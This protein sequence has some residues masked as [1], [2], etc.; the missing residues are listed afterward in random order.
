MN[1]Q[2]FAPLI[3]NDQYEKSRQTPE[4]VPAVIFFIL[5][6]LLRYQGNSGLQ[7]GSLRLSP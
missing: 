2:L 6:L 5:H 1:S 3:D 4:D 7:H